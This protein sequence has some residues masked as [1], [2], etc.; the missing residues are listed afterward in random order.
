MPRGI[1]SLAVGLFALT[2]T[3]CNGGQPPQPAN[4]RS[5]E[6][7]TLDAGVAPVQKA[8]GKPLF[9]MAAAG[10]PAAVAPQPRSGLALDPIVVP[11]CRLTV[12]DK[13][14]VPSQR[15]G[16]LLVIGTEVQ[17]DEHI[18]ADRLLQVTIGTEERRFRRL[19]EGD[20]VQ[21]NQLL[22]QLDDR[23]ARDDFAIK[24]ARVAATRADQQATIATRDE[25]E[26]RYQRQQRLAQTHST[27]QE[28]VD[29]ARLLVHRYAYEAV[30]RAKAVILA[31][32][33]RNQARTVLHMHQI[34]S[35]IPG[36]IKGI[37]KKRG[38]FVKSSE[39]VVQ[40]HNLDRLRVEGLVEMQYL[41]RL[42]Q[43]MR[44]LIEPALSESPRQTLVGHLQEVTSVA[45]SKD[46]KRPLIVSASEDGTVRVWGRT[47]RRETRLLQHP[48]AV[49]AV[50]CTPPG[51]AAN[52]CL[53]GAED[54]VA[55][56]WDLDGSGVK[57]LR[58]LK[59]QHRRGVTCV[60]FSPD[61]KTCATGGDDSEICLWDAQAGSLRYRFPAGH[62]AAVTS[63]QFTPRSQL[64][65]AGRD[66][67]LRL[68][69][70]GRE[71]ARLEAT[72]DRRSGDVLALG[73]SPDGGHMLYDQGRTLRLLSVAERWT[74]GVLEQPS[75]ATNFGTFALFSPDGRLLV[76]AGASEGRLQL[77]RRPTDT[78][79]GAELK[80]LVPKDRSPATCAAFA[81][82]GS[83]L[84]S[85]TRDREV[86]VWR[87]P[88]KEEIE[89]QLTAEVTL[90]EAAV[91]SSA[92]Q[93]RVWAELPNPGGRLLPGNTVTMVI[94]GE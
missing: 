49:L 50:A 19:Q 46:P 64:V 6:E 87:L 76:T 77:W 71:G 79:R 42:R 84:V 61:G 57:P 29:A 24:D 4:S 85:G 41:P 10:A 18:P 43:G 23:L 13:Q 8:I 37:H 11:E 33:E 91:E 9:V 44:V 93:V 47:A 60:A 32:R 86:L 14:D 58:E 83:F 38:E 35:A 65:S 27:S 5:A 74:D 62:R 25:S 2:I 70:L 45:V 54:G 53:S 51:A 1:H 28:E 52:W 68:W 67:T 22:A 31:D 48:T 40:V 82:D 55:R 72:V 75:G 81:P 92:R 15:D 12:L 63:L 56:I 36:V 80:Q 20:H 26:V 88:Q 3:A 39:P 90:I 16:V 34:R 21:A 69:T 59:G 66:N 73:V 7:G 30:S 78:A 17:D 89:G 94:P